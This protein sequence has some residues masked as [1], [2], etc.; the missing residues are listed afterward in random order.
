M[1]AEFLRQK[2]QRSHQFLSQSFDPFAETGVVADVQ[3]VLPSVTFQASG[4]SLVFQSIDLVLA[5]WNQAGFQGAKPILPPPVE[6]DCAQSGA[7]QFGQRMMR[8][9]LATIQ[10]E[11]DFITEKYSTQEVVILI[12]LP[13]QNGSVAKSPA[14]PHRAQN[15]TRRECGFGLAIGTLNQTDRLDA[16]TSVRIWFRFGPGTFQMLQL[17]RCRKSGIGRARC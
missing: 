1:S 10:K 17:A 6:C 14:L 11:R 5:C 13:H 16:G 8:N 2:N 12:E 3:P 7:R 15:F 4:Q 9:R